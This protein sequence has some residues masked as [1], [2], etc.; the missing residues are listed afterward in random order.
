MSNYIPRRVIRPYIIF[1]SHSNEKLANQTKN[2]IENYAKSKLAWRLAPF[3]VKAIVAER[4]EIPGEH[5]E[6]KLGKMIQASSRVVAI[7]T[8]EVLKSKWVK[9]EMAKAQKLEKKIIPFAEDKDYVVAVGLSK[10]IEWHLLEKNNLKHV[11]EHVVE[12]IRRSIPGLYLL[13]GWRVG[14]L[15]RNVRVSMEKRKVENDA[16]HWLQQRDIDP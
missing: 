3:G 2:E 7:L 12:D 5:L 8:I 11:A 4:K 10:N 1:I 16:W 14:V 13:K 15:L 6:E 9:W